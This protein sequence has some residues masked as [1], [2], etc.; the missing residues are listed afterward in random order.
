MNISIYIIFYNKHKACH[1]IQTQVELTFRK[2][3][4][5]I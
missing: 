2:S 1:K 5:D 4:L 3:V